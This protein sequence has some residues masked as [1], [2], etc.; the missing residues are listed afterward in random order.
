[1]AAWA[2]PVFN[3]HVKPN[4]LQTLKWSKIRMLGPEHA[5]TTLYC[6]TLVI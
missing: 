2:Y 1:M 6:S 3:V 4:W 5:C